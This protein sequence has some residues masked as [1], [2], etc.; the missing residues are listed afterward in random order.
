MQEISGQELHV[1]PLSIVSG[2][3]QTPHCT[4]VNTYRGPCLSNTNQV[5]MHYVVRKSD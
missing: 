1:L 3:L 2:Q 5:S 4:L